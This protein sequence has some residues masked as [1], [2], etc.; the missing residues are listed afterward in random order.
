MNKVSGVKDTLVKLEDRSHNQRAF[1]EL[2]TATKQRF[3]SW[4]LFTQPCLTQII[5]IKFTIFNRA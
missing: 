3:D 5:R 1:N 4:A 2:P